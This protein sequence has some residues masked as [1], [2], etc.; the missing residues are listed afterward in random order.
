MPNCDSDL[1][2]TNV[3]VVSNRLPVSVK[4]LDDGTYDF[5]VSSGG[6]VGALQ[7]LS[8]SVKFKWYGWPG[9][10]VPDRERQFVKDELVKHNAVPVFLEKELAEKHYNGFSS[11]L[12]QRPRLIL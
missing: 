2:D 11:R 1:G 7:G 12:L 8:Q 6:L 4:L 10:Y 9:Q 3:F 5:K